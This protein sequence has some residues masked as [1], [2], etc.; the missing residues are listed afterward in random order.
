MHRSERRRSFVKMCEMVRIP[1]LELQGSRQGC[2]GLIKCILSTWFV[3]G[4]Q[5][6]QCMRGNLLFKAAAVWRLP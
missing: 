2:V 4:A 6:T 3:R 1:F 5:V